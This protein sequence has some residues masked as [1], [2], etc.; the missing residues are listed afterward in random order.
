MEK[1]VLMID[2]DVDDFMLLNEVLAKYPG[3]RCHYACNAATGIALMKD[4]IPDAVLLDINMPGINGPQCLKMIMSTPAIAHVPVIVFSTSI[5]QELR[6]TMI[7]NGAKSCLEKPSS[8]KDYKKVVQAL[9]NIIY[10][11]GKTLLPK[12]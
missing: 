2:D 6:D 12:S 11:D 4:N 3:L 5:T 8:Y 9:M 10:A 1:Y 7:S